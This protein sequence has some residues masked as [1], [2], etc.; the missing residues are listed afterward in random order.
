[1]KTNSIICGNSIE[2]IKNID[3]NSVHLILSDI[4]YGISLDTWGILHNNTN[5][6]LL[7]MSPA[8]KQSKE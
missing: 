7:G 2:E 3:S 5:S 1:M 8:Q 4:P 6:S